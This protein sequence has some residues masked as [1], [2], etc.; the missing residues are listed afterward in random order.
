MKGKFEVSF[1]QLIIDVAIIAIDDGTRVFSKER[2]NVNK[3]PEH[4]LAG[5]TH[6]ERI[7]QF[8]TFWFK[9]A[10]FL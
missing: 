1:F 6:T 5:N 7:V 4:P 2:L 8:S 9:S 3:Q 10:G